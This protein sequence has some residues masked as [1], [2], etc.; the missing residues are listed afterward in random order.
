MGLT[1]LCFL[2]AYDLVVGTQKKDAKGV[3]CVLD[4]L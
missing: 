3:Q 4:L 2:K 1:L